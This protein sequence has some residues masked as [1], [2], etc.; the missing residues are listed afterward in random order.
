ML[1]IRFTVVHLCL[2]VVVM[3][4]PRLAMAQ[5]APIGD[6]PPAA[7]EPVERTGLEALSRV[8]GIVQYFHPTD[9]VA[10]VDWGPWTTEAVRIMGRTKTREDRVAS[11]RR[12]IAPVAPLAEITIGE[13]EDAAETSAVVG[14][15]TRV[16]YWDHDGV[17][18]REAQSMY[19]SQREVIEVDDE[20]WDRVF[21]HGIVIDRHLGDDV[22]LRI[23]IA[24]PLDDAGASW[25]RAQ[26]VWVPAAQRVPP[27]E[28]AWSMSASDRASRLA[29]VILTW[30]GF[31]HFYPYFDVI[32]TDWDAELTVALTRA[33]E[34]HDA[35]SMLTTMRKLIARLHDGHANVYHNSEPPT[36]ALPLAWTWVGDRLVITETNWDDA[37]GP[38]PG[39]E[40]LAI[41][42]Q[43]IGALRA[44]VESMISGAPQ[45]RRWRSYAMLRAVEGAGPST[46]RIRQPDGVVRDVDVKHVQPGFVPSE[47]RPSPIW[48]VDPGVFYVDISRINDDTFKAAVPRLEKA[49]GLVFDLR[50]YPSNLSTIVIAHLIDKPV[51]SPQWHIPTPRYPN[52]AHLTFRRAGWTVTPM[53]PRLEANVAFIIDGRAIS[54]AETYMG[55]IEHAG[56][57]EIVGEATAGTNG[58][59]N[60]F[61]MP[62]GYRIAWTGMKVLKHD[63]TPHHIIGVEPTVPVDRTVEGIAARRDELL[64]A[65][66]SLVRGDT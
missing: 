57:A 30:N 27:R 6:L 35:R 17:N 15:C 8:V 5:P 58:N 9:E 31:E 19:R 55:I 4:L 34:D 16:R 37:L 18:M 21:P 14:P 3:S 52:R 39:D 1:R 48:E 63:G 33:A 54:Y 44:E 24:V 38:V 36:L 50:G 7:L 26:S 51:T 25:P 66:I 28:P 65:A 60:V 46:L 41:N 53:E 20:Q 49:D 10:D 62:C 29:T 47:T 56:V 61:E 13:S 32:D 11:L 43:D 64:E 12:I 59:V 42:G 40:V 22:W 2:I 23:P 45:W